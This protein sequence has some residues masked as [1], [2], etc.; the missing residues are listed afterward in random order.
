MARRLT[1]LT[2]TCCCWIGLSGCADQNKNMDMSAMKTPPRPVELDK[3]EP[4][5][6]KWE[7]TSVMTMPDG[8]TTM[9]ATSS[10]EFMWELGKRFLVEK[11]TCK[12]GDMEPME[13]VGVYGYDP[14]AKEYTTSWYSSMGEASH[15]EMKYSDKKGCWCMKGRYRDAM[16]G[17]MVYGEGHMKMTDA[18][19]IEMTWT[20]WDSMKLMKQFEMKGTSHRKS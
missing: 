5:V 10:S 9:N 15:G 8:K 2:C 14:A 7:G 1:L 18:N 4:F 19:T 16:S 6:G 3:L 11:G 12:M 17:K 20:Q 13:M